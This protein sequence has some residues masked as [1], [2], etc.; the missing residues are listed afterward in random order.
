MRVHVTAM[1]TSVLKVNIVMQESPYGEESQF[2]ARIGEIK[3]ELMPSG[4]QAA[5]IFFA[6]N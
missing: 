4:F 1:E 3:T 2:V 5:R 6:R